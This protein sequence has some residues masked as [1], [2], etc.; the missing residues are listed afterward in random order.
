MSEPKYPEVEVQLTGTDG[1]A[2]AILTKMRVAM[3]RAGFEVDEI[4]EFSDEAMA[5][6]YDHLLQTCMKWVTVT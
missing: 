6:N 3:K 1:N 2:Y 5:G 4:R